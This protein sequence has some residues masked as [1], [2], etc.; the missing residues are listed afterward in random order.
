MINTKQVRE[1]YRNGETYLSDIPVMCGEIENLRAENEALGKRV[2]TVIRSKSEALNDWLEQKE[3]LVAENA[4]LK[5]QARWIPVDEK[6]PQGACLVFIEEEIFRSKVHAGSFSYNP[7]TKKGVDLV[8]AHFAFDMPKVTHW[9]P[10]PDTP[11]E[12]EEP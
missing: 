7:D 10:L 4:R 9:R 5:E 3:A 1:R 12:T 6:P 8:A 2:E 11:E